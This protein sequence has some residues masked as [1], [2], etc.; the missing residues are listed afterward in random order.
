V[1][2][3]PH[4]D[5][6]ASQVFCDLTVVDVSGSVATSYASKLFA[7]YGAS[8]INVEPPEGF[9]TRRLEPM[10]SSGDSAMHGYLHTNKYS[11]LASRSLFQDEPVASQ[12]DLVV[13]DPEN[14]PTTNYLTDIDINTCAVSWYGLTGRCSSFKGSNAAVHALSGLMRGIGT[15][16]GPP[17]IPPGYQA[18]M[19]GGLSA[20]NGALGHLLAQR[21][22]N[23]KTPFELDASI[24]EANM[25]FTDLGAINAYNENPLPP[26]M[27]INRFPPTYPLGIWPCK[28][29]W[30]GV[31]NLTPGQWKAFCQLL[32]LEHFAD[33]ELFQSSVNRLAASD[34]LEPEILKALAEHSAE[35]LF[36]RGQAMRIPL[37]RVPT[38]EELFSVDQYQARQ[39]FSTVVQGAD[40]FRVPSTPFRLFRTLPHF[41]GLVAA[42]GADTQRWQDFVP[43][44]VKDPTQ[45][46]PSS[47]SPPPNSA[48]AKP[49][50]GLRIIDLSMGWAGPLATRNLA[51]MGAQVIKVESCE[52]FDWWRSWEATEEWIA[53]DG[54]EKSLQY[55]YVNRNKLDITLDLEHP[56]GR[57]L[58]LRLVATADALVENYSG[59]VLPKLKLSYDHLIEANPELVMVSMPAFGSTGPWA[60]FR[61]YGST[62]EHSSGLPHLGGRPR[63]SADYAACGLWRRSGRI[64]RQRGDSHR[65]VAQAAH[66][67]G[68]VCRSQPSGVPFPLGSSGHFAPIGAR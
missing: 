52:R 45:G 30:L 27:G 49:L 13:F 57:E 61:A 20:F 11:V 14:L 17:V 54:A 35:D 68:T 2:I 10:L 23:L 4:S 62:V 24:L 56:T 32:N 3:A 43:D 51:D 7:D 26:R 19:I 28:D 42:I 47:Y 53:D 29:G 58:L 64:K 36:Y 48:A 25:C 8:V 5:A 21:L 67:R 6:L 34:L 55:L 60:E 40:T 15:V 12:A 37:A 33:I 18:Q 39:A 31:T 16:E 38:M 50:E 44:L 41:G 22:G 59:S 66:W 65:V 1:T 63:P 9:Q 46:Q